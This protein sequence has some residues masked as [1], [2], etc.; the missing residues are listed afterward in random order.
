MQRM[1]TIALSCLAALALAGCASTSMGPS[2]EPSIERAGNY[3]AQ[4][5]FDDAAR[6][7][8]ALANTA[9]GSEATDLRL[10]AARAWLAARQPDEAQ[11]VLDQLG[12]PAG[13]AALDRR[14][15]EVEILL[16]RGQS[17]EGWNALAAIPVPSADAA[18]NAQHERYYAVRTRAALATSRY[19]EAVRAQMAREPL[20]PSEQARQ[21]SRAELLASLRDASERGA[22]ISPG[23]ERD[24]I[25]RGWLELAPA[26]ASAARAP[27]GTSA[28]L[29]AWK[30]RYPTHPANAALAQELGRQV[31]AGPAK[32]AGGGQ[33]SHIALLLPVSG[34]QAG[35]AA[36]IRDG[37]LT[38]YYMSAPA[39]RPE[40]RIYDTASGSAGDV[41][42]AATAAGAN[43]IVG[44]LLREEVAGAAAFAARRPP[45]L[46]LNFLG[47]GDPVPEGFYQFALSPENEARAIARRLVA[48]GR[49]RGVALV[50]TGE[51]GARVLAAFEEELKAGGGELLASATFV[52]SG[53][54]F[55]GPIT[56]VLRIDDSRARHRR[57]EQLLGTKLSF[58]PRRR[59]D[60]QFVFMPAQ[61]QVARQL[62]P[63][64]R[65]H[66]AGDLPAYTTSDAYEPHASA[67]Q[68]LDG[69]IFP[70]MPWVLSD[71]GEVLEVRT[72]L[73][74][75]WGESGAARSKLFAF[76]FD[77]YRLA[78]VLPAGA[79]GAALPGLTGGINVE[80]DHRVRR[81]LEW[82]QIR[83][84]QPVRL[85]AD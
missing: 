40:L 51:W 32:P 19:A 76:G 28:A 37:F 53:A 52:A 47:A 13:A 12:T 62:R 69:V 36:Q 54:D 55:S 34:R 64:L 49:T 63:Q 46:A 3:A 17:A 59:G 27:G 82:A 79:T 2:G 39:A 60:A 56:S 68:D 22:R 44:P 66:Y 74:A 38:A 20:M 43:L 73:R 71:S 8:E 58:E 61:A 5:E 80:A 1:R 30:S 75:A 10:R 50:P 65:F 57:M 67:N 15:V 72:A 25:V 21:A 16:A 24:P 9:T 14:L 84:G 77:A 26:A 6:L 29:E 11:R 23:N 70:D 45:I 41:I 18:S 33:A 7:Y 85:G 31:T 42:A 81:E 35:S 4:G 78:L 48:E 83:N